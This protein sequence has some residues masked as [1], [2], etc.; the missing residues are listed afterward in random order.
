[1]FLFPF[2]ADTDKAGFALNLTLEKPVFDGT[3]HPLP[4]ISCVDKS[5]PSVIAAMHGVDFNF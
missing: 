3:T 4:L 5:W 2:K 1:M